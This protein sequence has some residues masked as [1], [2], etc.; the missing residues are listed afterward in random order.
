MKSTQQEQHL[1]FAVIATDVS[2][3]TLTE[4]KLYVRLMRVDRPPSYDGVP[5]LP[6]GLIQPDETAEQAVKRI[7]LQKGL[8]RPS[9]AHIEQLYTF[10]AIDR[11]PRGRVVS[12]AYSAY[13]PW[14][15]LSSDEQR[16]TDL[17]WWSPATKKQTLAYDHT[18]ILATA[19]DRLKTRIRYTSLIQYLL[20]I[21]FTLTQLEAF[22]EVILSTTID[23]RNFRKKFE[24][25][26]LLKDTG[27]STQGDKHRP[28]KLYQFKSTT[29]TNIEIL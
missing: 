11:D 12:V 7:L 17:V 22:Y 3:F 14:S 4:G 18:H 27:K 29:L 5:G 28:A 21:S 2:L 19:I 10:S 25:L 13:V 20:P 6:G 16:D 15:K 26:Q 23:K 8:V 1:K 9:I 24:K